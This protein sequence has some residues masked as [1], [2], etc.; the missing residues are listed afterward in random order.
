[1][2]Q[3]ILVPVDGSA[4]AQRGLEEATR[5]GKLTQGR[6]RLIHVIDELS[7]ALAMDAY[8]GHAGDW[9]SLLRVDG[10]RLLAQAKAVAEA[11]GVEADTVLYD[12]RSGQVDELVTAEAARWPADL[13][14]LGTHGRRGVGRVLM[15]SSAEHILR[16]APVPVLLVRAPESETREPLHVRQP[17]GALAFE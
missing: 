15:G 10:E 17:T 11:A 3:R 12:R 8:A 13:I 6:L 1:M 14:V 2:Y 16:H 4:T 5:L 7:F 9:L